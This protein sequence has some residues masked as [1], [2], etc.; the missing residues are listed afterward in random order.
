MGYLGAV[1][2]DVHQFRGYG[3]TLKVTLFSVGSSFRY[4]TGI[5][6]PA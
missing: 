3:R 1:V 2:T 5:N 4:E 6:V